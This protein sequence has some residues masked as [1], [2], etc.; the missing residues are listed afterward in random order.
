MPTTITSAEA[1]TAIREHLHA[2]AKAGAAAAGKTF[3]APSLDTVEQR[4]HTAAA[5]L[6]ALRAALGACG[7]NA[8]YID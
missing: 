6:A 7:L 4:T 1:L 2:S 3:G 8:N 5:A